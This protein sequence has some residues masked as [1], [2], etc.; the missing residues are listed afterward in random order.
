[1]K[2]KLVLL[3]AGGTG[4]H[5]FPAQALSERLLANGWRVKLSTDIRGAR[6]LENFSPNIEVNILPSATLFGGGLLKRLIAPWLIF[7][8]SF[9]SIINFKR[10]RPCIVV[11]FGGYPTVPG[12][13]AAVLLKIPIVIQEQNGVLGIVNRVFSSKA[14]ILA[15]GTWP[16]KAPEKVKKVFTGNPVRLSIMKK[17]GSPYIPPGEYPMSI[18]VIGGSQG[19]SILSKIIPRAFSL[20]SDSILKN[21]RVSHQAR[22]EDSCYVK[23]MYE[24]L[25][26]NALVRPFFVDIE[27]RYSE[28]QLIISR[29]GASSVADISIIGRPSILIPFAAALADHQTANAKSLSDN[30]AAIL[31]PEKDVSP[32]IIAREIENILSAPKLAQSMA[33]KALS[34]SNPEAV[35]KLYD[36]VCFVQRSSKNDLD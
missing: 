10:D 29:A 7:K 20:L 22:L 23:G 14:K 36:V 5:M 4:G 25:G 16:T 32:E 21:L 8:G 1:M 9:S 17:A 12:L 15:C 34:S 27:N 30:G 19:A 2:G 31:I 3:S 24:V 26:V 35:K 11:G 13:V 33:D 6:Y 28:A 18:L